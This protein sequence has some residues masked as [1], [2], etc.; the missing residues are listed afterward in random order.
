VWGI[1]AINRVLRFLILLAECLGCVAVAMAQTDSSSL[2]LKANITAQEYC[3]HGSDMTALLI[4][5]RLRYTNTGPRKLILYKGDDLFYQAKIRQAGTQSGGRPY[6]I[7]VLNARYLENEN[8]PLEQGL[9][10]RL[11][12]ILSPGASYQMETTV[13]VGVAGRAVARDRH[14]IREGEHTLQ[15]V[16]STWY[17]S[18]KLAE[19]LRTQWQP[20]GLLWFSPVASNTLTFRAARPLSLQPCK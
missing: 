4:R 14:A 11:F 17:R 13:G 20:K 2:T 3:A 18:R 9:S 1:T 8:E 19:Q 15:L 10:G 6:E 16:V 7:V 12:V 5:V